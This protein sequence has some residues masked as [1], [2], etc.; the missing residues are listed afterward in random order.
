MQKSFVSF[1]RPVLCF[2]GTLTISIRM[3][4]SKGVRTCVNVYMYEFMLLLLSLS[5]LVYG[6][7][8]TTNRIIGRTM[9]IL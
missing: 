7:S 8:V 5:L 2:A 3:S 6:I 4:I 9:Y 1:V